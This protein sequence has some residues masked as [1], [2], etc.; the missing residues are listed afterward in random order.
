MQLGGALMTLMVANG[1]TDA[2]K[3]DVCG[4]L[5][6][7]APCWSYRMVRVSFRTL[8]ASRFRIESDGTVSHSQCHSCW[9]Y[10]AHRAGC[11]LAEKLIKDSVTITIDQELHAHPNDMP[12][13]SWWE[14]AAKRIHWDTEQ[15][16]MAQPD[17]SGHTYCG[18]AVVLA[19]EL[20]HA[21]LDTLS[22][23]KAVCG[24]N[25][26]RR[27][28]GLPDRLLWGPPNQKANCGQYTKFDRIDDGDILGCRCDG[29]LQ[30]ILGRVLRWISAV[31]GR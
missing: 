15:D 16:S 24:E 29:L 27:E 20:V 17:E 22:E 14:P 4:A 23:E 11:N 18:K 28:L 19:H 12:G 25:Q 8:F 6:T 30:S 1:S 9:R 10:C 3:Q 21:Y 7:I 2:F 5:S 31:W 26:I 13:T